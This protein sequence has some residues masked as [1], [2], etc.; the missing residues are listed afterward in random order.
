MARGRQDKFTSPKLEVVITPEQHEQAVRSNSGGCLIAD[1]IK[2]QYPQLSRV[3]VDMATIRATD[4]KRGLRFTWLCPPAGQH[5]LLAYDQGWPQPTD[6]VVAKR[7]VKIVPV[8]RSKKGRDSVAA[9]A[10]RREE[11][12]AELEGKLA[13]GDELTGGEKRALSRMR[14]A[15]P[16]PERPSSRGAVDVK[17]DEHHGTVVYGGP[18]L[19]QGKAHPNLLRGRDRHFGAKLADPGVAF[20]EAVEAA[21]AERLAERDAAA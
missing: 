14:N 7:A 16:A 10:A 1:A 18:P 9:V 8:T 3:V 20:R 12:V 2:K 4:L 21:V 15:K 6:R 19:V 17:V 11:R 5:V 13:V